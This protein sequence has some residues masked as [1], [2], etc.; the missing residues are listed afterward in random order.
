MYSYSTRVITIAV[1]LTGAL[2]ATASA[3]SSGGDRAVEQFTCKDFL[4]ETGSSRDVAVAFLHGYLL[5]KSGT[6]KFNLDTLEKQ[7]DAFIERCLDNPQEKAQDAMLKVK[8]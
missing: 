4:R 8:G 5:G 1:I 7:T 3:Q 6:S 2:A